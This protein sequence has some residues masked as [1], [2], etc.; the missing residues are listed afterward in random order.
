MLPSNRTD[1]AFTILRDLYGVRTEDLTA[2][3]PGEL[4]SKIQ[5]VHQGLSAEHEFAAIASWL[6]RC[7]LLTQPD[8]VLVSDGRYRAPDFLIAVRSQER[9][10]P[11][12]VEVKTTTDSRLKWTES[13]FSSLRR[14]ACLL[15]LPLLVA[16][17][18]HGLWVLTDT[19][20][21]EKR[22]TAYHLTFDRAIKNSLMTQL[23]GNVWLKIAEDFRLE[24][25]MRILDPIDP[26]AESLPEGGYRCQIE[27]AGL[28]TERGKVPKELTSSL[29]PI[30][31]VK[32]VD[33]P[34]T[35][36]KADLVTEVFPTDPEGMFN[37]SDVLLAQLN[38]RRDSEEN[39]DWIAELRKGLPRQ[40]ADLEA[41]LQRGLEVGAL[42]YILRQQPQIVPD[43]LKDAPN[44]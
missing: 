5:R 7:T 27:A 9:E 14:F 18:S 22:K 2:I 26:T 16:W 11:F 33:P 42:R 36:R 41:V 30:F 13:Y 23:F 25:Q 38:W 29:F 37:L 15:K 3:D 43:F 1:L 31:L 10:I 24:I 35:E 17:K 32:A 21:F 4:I 39:I 28:W 20:L 19:E 6:G 44:H 12:L 40:L 8:Q 34:R